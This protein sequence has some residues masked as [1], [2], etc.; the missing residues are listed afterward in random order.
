VSVDGDWGPDDEAPAYSVADAAR[1]LHVPYSTLQFWVKGKDY[2][3]RGGRRR[4]VPVIPLS[5]PGFLSYRNLVEA[6]LL[7]GLRRHERITLPKVR[8][9]IARVRDEFGIERLLSHPQLAAAPGVLFLDLYS[10]LLDL[11]T[12]SQLALRELFTAHMARLEWDRNRVKRLYPFVQRHTGTP[13]PD[14]PRIVVIDP[15][16]A[17]GVPTVARGVRT[18]IVLD[19]FEAGDKI[20]DLAEDY[21]CSTEEIEEAIRYERAARTVRKAA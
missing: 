9:A 19:R 10:K 6:H 11:S 5:A 20:A 13:R 16:V 3:A 12:D 7:R 8:E 18:E 4:A 21:D 2:P 14:E 17:F 15:R 1:F